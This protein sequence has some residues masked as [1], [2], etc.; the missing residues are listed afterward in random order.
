MHDYLSVWC[1]EIL[2][3][4]VYQKVLTLKIRLK[5]D[6]TAVTMKTTLMHRVKFSLHNEWSLVQLI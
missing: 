3:P 6:M 2:G 4:P 1:A 5:F